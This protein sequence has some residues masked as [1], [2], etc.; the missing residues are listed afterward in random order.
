MDKEE[1][2]NYFGCNLLPKHMTL[3]VFG[4]MVKSVK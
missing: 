3:D 4:F 1:L 2:D